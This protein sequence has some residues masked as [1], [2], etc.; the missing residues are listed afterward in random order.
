MRWAVVALAVVLLAAL[1]WFRYG[2]ARAAA[3]AAAPAAVTFFEFPAPEPPVEPESRTLRGVV[4][5][6]DGNRAPYA[7]LRANVHGSP[8]I[9]IFGFADGD[10][11]FEMPVPARRRL[12]RVDLV[13]E[14][15]LMP[16]NLF[17]LSQ[18]QLASGAIQVVLTSMTLRGRTVDRDL[19]PLP[20]ATIDILGTPPPSF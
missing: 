10:G 2:P 20:Y 9:R 7:I 5:L 4:F 13:V 17:A 1:L 15:P 6:Q 19:V 14:H 3:Q 12:A 11:S 8:M 18:E 16:R